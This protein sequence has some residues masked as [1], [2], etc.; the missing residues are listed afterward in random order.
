MWRQGHVSSQLDQDR[1]HGVLSLPLVQAGQLCWVD[2]ASPSIHAWQVHLGEELQNRRLVR[3]VVVTM[4]LHAVDSVLVHA[5]F[6]GQH[7]IFLK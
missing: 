4:Y 1:F 3:V 6:A 7:T 5:L 2:F